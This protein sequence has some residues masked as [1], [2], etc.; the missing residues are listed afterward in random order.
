MYQHVDQQ[1]SLLP[2]NNQDLQ[3][4]WSSYCDQQD[5]SSDSITLKDYLLTTDDLIRFSRQISTGMEYL[6]A[7]F[8]IHRDLAARNVLIAD[9][10][11]LKISDFGLAKHGRESYAVSNVFVSQSFELELLIFKD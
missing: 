2:L 8:I 7:R 11:V 9:N 1:G 5:L 6:S 4:F 3:D 10:H